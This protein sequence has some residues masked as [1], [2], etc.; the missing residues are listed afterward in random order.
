MVETK[1]LPESTVETVDAEV[2]TI[3]DDITVRYERSDTYVEHCWALSPEAADAIKEQAKFQF[4]VPAIEATKQ[5]QERTLQT[6]EVTRQTRERT[7][8]HVATCIVVV[9][10]FVGCVIRPEIAPYATGIVAVLAGVYYAVLRRTP[11]EGAALPPAPGES[12]GRGPSL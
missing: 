5:E 12:V 7:W 8:Q 4:A 9:L 2:V 6:K 3:G 1:R 10:A 11:R